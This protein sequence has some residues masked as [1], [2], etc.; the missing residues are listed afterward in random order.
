MNTLPPR[1]RRAGRE[2][3]LA[4]ALR[5]FLRD[6]IRATS[7]Q[8]IAD[9]SGVT[10]AGLYY[11]Y[12]AKDEIVLDVLKPLLDALPAVTRRAEAHRTHAAQVDEVLGGLIEIALDEHAGFTVLMNDPYLTQLLSQQASMRQWWDDTA[13]LLLG[14]DPDDQT[15]IG[16][17]MFING[18]PGASRDPAMAPLDDR[19]R[20]RHLLECGRRLLQPG[21]AIGT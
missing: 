2:Q 9:E 10:K 17:A 16:L 4:A 13:A 20:R 7:L 3:L 18:L 1:R 15:R 19:S 8:A 5:L 6:G 14:P 11:H 21:R 12:K